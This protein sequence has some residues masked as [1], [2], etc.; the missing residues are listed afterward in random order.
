MVGN[1]KRTL[2]KK[3]FKHGVTVSNDAAFKEMK[4]A[5]SNIA[6]RAKAKLVRI[7]GDMDKYVVKGFV[8]TVHEWSNRIAHD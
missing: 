2:D 4:A 8:H 3:A 5:P 1:R 6:K 7:V